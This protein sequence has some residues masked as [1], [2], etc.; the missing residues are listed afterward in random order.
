VSPSHAKEDSNKTANELGPLLGLLIC[1]LLGVAI[2]FTTRAMPD[3]VISL[4]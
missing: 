3:R 2:Y 4:R 1:A